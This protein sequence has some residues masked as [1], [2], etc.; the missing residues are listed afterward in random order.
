M[1]H[2]ESDKFAELIQV[3]DIGFPVAFCFLNSIVFYSPRG[4]SYVEDAFSALLELYGLEDAGFET[5][6][7]II[8]SEIKENG[9]I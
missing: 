9:I 5:L 7:D 1:N 8:E 3:H 2:R 4:G 6:Q